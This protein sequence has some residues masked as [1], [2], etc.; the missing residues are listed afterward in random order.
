MTKQTISLGLSKQVFTTDSFEELLEKD[1]CVFLAVSADWCGA[2]QQMKP[3][4]FALAKL[5]KNSKAVTVGAMNIDENEVDRRYFPERHIP[6]VKLLKKLPSDDE[7]NDRP[8]VISYEGHHHLPGWLQFLSE[9]T[10]LNLQEILDSNYD[11]YEFGIEELM[12]DLTSAARK[13]LKEYWGTDSA[14]AGSGGDELWIRLLL[15]RTTEEVEKAGR[16][17][18]LRAG[19]PRKPLDFLLKE[20]PAVGQNQ[21]VRTGLHAEELLSVTRGGSG[22]GARTAAQ[23]WS[24]VEQQKAIDSRA[25]KR[26]QTIQELLT[27]REQASVLWLAAANN[28]LEVLPDS[29]KIVLQFCLAYGADPHRDTEGVLPTEA[30]AATGALQALAM[31]LR[32]GLTPLGVAVCRDNEEV[33]KLLL[34]QPLGQAA[35][36]CWKG[37]RPNLEAPKAVG[38][39]SVQENVRAVLEPHRWTILR[40]LCP[41]GKAPQQLHVVIKETV[42][43]CSGVGV[44]RPTTMAALLDDAEAVKLLAKAGST[45]SDP[46]DPP[47]P[48][49]VEVTLSNTD[50]E[51]LRRLGR[52]RR[53]A[54]DG[55]E[56]ARWLEPGTT[57]PL[58]GQRW[59]PGRGWASHGHPMGNPMGRS[60]RKATWCISVDIHGDVLGKAWTTVGG[61]WSL[62]PEALQHLAKATPM[63]R[64]QE[65]REKMLVGPELQ[66]WCS[67]R[68]MQPGINDVAQV[69]EEKPPVLAQ[70]P[71]QPPLLTRVTSTQVE[72][73]DSAPSHVDIHA[74]SQRFMVLLKAALNTLPS[75]RGPCYRAILG[76]ELAPVTSLKHYSP[77]SIIRWPFGACG[78]LD[79]SSAMTC[80]TQQLS[81]GE[82][83]G[84]RGV[85]FKVRRLL[86]AKEVDDSNRQASLGGKGAGEWLVV[87]VL[88][89]EE[90]E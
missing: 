11:A 15:K 27:R 45:F 16:E 4:W 14:L 25:A 12:K 18:A 52:A 56:T 59:D 21:M 64:L 24:A 61:N 50:L 79:F 90:E 87:M 39:Q 31:L 20:A 10:D 36:F 88:L 70:L 65:L 8:V 58:P 51:G 76:S 38:S 81:G 30:A 43:E 53:Q 37:L 77:G 13:A 34:Q 26:M 68:V 1:K 69:E 54:Q 67:S 19:H 72:Q 42:D 71:S 49:A 46:P 80:L 9:H 55:G 33:I 78:T 7:Q 82:S 32:I 35:P 73:E 74:Q 28:D 57:G 22:E 41:E 3:A 47:V 60:S 83:R 62:L 6:V 17:K 23:Q 5:L 86:T 85:I 48:G 63:S 89:D 66:S 75:A 29:A 40:N 44:L 2:C 84:Y